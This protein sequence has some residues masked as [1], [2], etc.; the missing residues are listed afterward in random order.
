MQPKIPV[1]NTEQGV[2]SQLM[3]YMYI[4]FFFNKVFTF[5][6]LSKYYKY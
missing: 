1:G 3:I 2:H 6:Y 5:S 4:F